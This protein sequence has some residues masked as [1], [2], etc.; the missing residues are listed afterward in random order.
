MSGYLLHS[1]Q[2]LLRLFNIHNI[3]YLFCTLLSSLR[4]V[5]INIYQIHSDTRTCAWWFSKQITVVKRKVKFLVAKYMWKYT[6]INLK[7]KSKVW[8]E[9]RVSWVDSDG[10]GALAG[11]FGTELTSPPSL[12]SVSGI[13]S[14]LL[15]RRSDTR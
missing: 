6:W 2:T 7:L 3:L 5:Y 1:K 10:A 11:S 13:L 9:L 15:T 12:S 14:D 4:N 8:L